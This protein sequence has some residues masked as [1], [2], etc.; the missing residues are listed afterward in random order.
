MT[1]RSRIW[2]ALTSLG[3]LALAAC[4]DRNAVNFDTPVSDRARAADW[5]AL[6]PIGD[7]VPIEAATTTPETDLTALA[8]RARALRLRARAMQRPIL[9]PGEATRLGGG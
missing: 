5:P 6:R 9:T 7:F 4:T 1:H 8:D 2:G 3:I